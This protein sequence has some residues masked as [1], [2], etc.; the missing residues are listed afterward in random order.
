MLVSRQD[1]VALVVDREQGVRLELAAPHAGATRWCV[2]RTDASAWA[3]GAGGL[4]RRISLDDG[5]RLAERHLARPVVDAV[6]S[7]EGGFLA[8]AIDNPPELVFVDRA[9]DERHRL[10]VSDMRGRLRSRAGAMIGAATRRSFLIALA[11]LPEFWEV[12]HDL[13]APEIPAGMIHDFQFREGAFVPGFLNP[14][15]IPVP[16]PATGLLTVSG[17]HEVLVTDRERTRVFN[18]DAR[19]ATRMALPDGWMPVVPSGSSHPFEHPAGS[20][21]GTLPDGILVGLDPGDGAVRHRVP[22]GAPPAAVAVSASGDRLALHFQA[23]RTGEVDSATPIAESVALVDARQG[24]LLERL[25]PAPGQ[26]VRAIAF[27]HI[28]VQ[29]WIATTDGRLFA[30]HA[31][32]QRSVGIVLGAPVAALLPI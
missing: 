23:N 21:W 6:L 29:P 5:S 11:D 27:D 3:V 1:G 18:L 9:G 7:S 10:P 15:R 13:A 17:G 20:L 12:S 2:D 4:L 16:A 31:S 25:R 28:G 30:A 14:R 8:L 26:V 24:R 22:L 32:T 19:R